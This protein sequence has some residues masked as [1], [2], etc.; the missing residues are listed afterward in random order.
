M[1][2]RYR[3]CI[4]L[5]VALLCA[6][7]CQSLPETRI[8]ID[9][10]LL[11]WQE[12]YPKRPIA[13]SDR[14]VYYDGEDIRITTI[15]P[16]TQDPEYSYPAVNVKALLRVFSGNKELTDSL[17]YSPPSD[18]TPHDPLPLANLSP[19]DTTRWGISGT[20][21][22]IGGY[23][24]FFDAGIKSKKFE[25]HIGSP[26]D[27]L[28]DIARRLRALHVPIPSGGNV[29]RPAGP[30]ASESYRD[31]MRAFARELL[32][33]PNG[34]RLRQEGLRRCLGPNPPGT[35]QGPDTSL[36]RDIVMQYA[37]E[38]GCDPD[39]AA[40]FLW[41]FCLFDIDSDCWEQ[42]ARQTGNERIVEAAKSRRSE[43]LKIRDSRNAH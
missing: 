25:F 5:I 4:L 6:L 21:L 29:I 3:H 18:V 41:G 14:S 43:L 11:K 15:L 16:A 32:A 37:S 13:R 30:P 26:P 23:W 35:Y 7:G 19:G 1:N 31:S 17:F 12:H 33:L 9:R 40:D 20:S 24:G 34:T 42:L 2:A 27:S 38:P 8:H 36:Y 28:V 22:A 39:H 10:D